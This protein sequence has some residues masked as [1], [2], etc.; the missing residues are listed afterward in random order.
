MHASSALRAPRTLLES[1]DAACELLHE[2]K[3]VMIADKRR[4]LDAVLATEADSVSTR[5]ITDTLQRDIADLE[6]NP[7]YL[8]YL[9]HAGL[10]DPD[11]TPDQTPVPTP[12]HGPMGAFVTKIVVTNDGQRLRDH[13]AKY[14]VPLRAW[15]VNYKQRIVTGGLPP[16]RKRKR[17]QPCTVPDQFLPTLCPVCG[18]ALIAASAGSGGALTCTRDG[19]S[20]MEGNSDSTVTGMPYDDQHDI[21]MAPNK[22]GYR[23]GNHMSECLNQRMGKE[24]TRI[25]IDVIDAVM[26]ERRKHVWIATED[27]TWDHMR[28][29]LS[30]HQLSKW[31]EHIP[32]I[33]S[34]VTG[35]T[36]STLNEAQEAKV[37][38][39]FLMLEAPFE[40]C[41]QH[42]RKRDNF[43]S[44]EY[45][46]Y[47]I[48]ELCGFDHMLDG[49]KLLKSPD[50]LAQHDAIWQFF[51]D[52]LNWTFIPTP[53]L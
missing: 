42:I 12:V 47:K 25:P 51:C 32:R 11:Q 24:S 43:P 2:K 46:L 44:Y 29:W 6:T 14:T 49:F 48:C 40:K 4:E 28:K 18:S 16:K 30:K 9:G 13:E 23:R 20:T 52:S 19:Y 1:H 27:I 26:L 37:R 17:R 10:S 45:I 50:K 8:E 3:D 15:H 21:I 35:C 39:M 5:A 36:L 38:S 41:P 22:G 31:Y 34:I 7:E 33:Y 53:V